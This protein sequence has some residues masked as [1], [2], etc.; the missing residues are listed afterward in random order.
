MRH[1]KLGREL[2][3]MLFLLEDHNLTISEICSK[4]ELSRRSFYYYMDFFRD[5]GFHVEVERKHYYRIRLDSPWFDKMN[6]SVNDLSFRARLDLSQQAGRNLLAVYE[7]IRNKQQVVLEGYG[8]V[9]SNTVRDR[10]VEPYML[11]NQCQEVRCYEPESGMSKTFKL[12]RVG[13]VQVLDEPWCHEDEHRQALTDAFSF[14]GDAST[15]VKLRM[16]RLAASL[17][18]EEHPAAAPFITP[19]GEDHWIASLPVCSYVGVGRFVL[20][21]LDDIDILE[22]EEFRRYLAD[23]VSAMRKKL[24]S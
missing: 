14:S 4:F 11:M 7:A 20:G 21:L 17:L 9:H 3:L 10:R 5:A 6:A 16:G 23:K 24:K 1:E 19:V 15:T 8:S 13:N 22:G 2:K 12:A 18:R